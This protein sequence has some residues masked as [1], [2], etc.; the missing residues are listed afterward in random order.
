MRTLSLLLLALLFAPLAACDGDGAQENTALRYTLSLQQGDVV[1]ATGELRF[2]AVP[3]SGAQNTGTFTLQQPGGDPLPPLTTTSGT[4]AASFETDGDLLV[5]INT[6]G[7][8]DSGLQL[9]GDYSAATYAGT[10]FEITIAGPQLQ[11]AFT[12]TAVED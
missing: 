4:F 9:R 11:G 5:R 10:W 7:T 1:A 3:R 2:D 6:A 8:S 12:A